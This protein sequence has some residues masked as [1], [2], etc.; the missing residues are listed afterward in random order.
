MLSLTTSKTYKKALKKL[1]RSGSFDG[2]KLIEIVNKLLNEEKLDEKHKDHG[3]NGI[4]AEY[5]DCHIHND[6]VLIYRIK[7]EDN[8][9]VLTNI[10]SHSDLFE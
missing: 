6:L 4:L 5:R 2:K 8:A 1:I 10:G 7:R 3:L 9:L